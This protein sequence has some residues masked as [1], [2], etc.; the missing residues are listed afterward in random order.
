LVQILREELRGIREACLT[1]SQEYRPKVTFV[2]VQ[3]RHHT[4][5]FPANAKD[6]V[7]KS[8]NVP[9]GAV[10]DQT[11]T[12]AGAFDFYLC[13]H[14]G[15]QVPRCALSD[16]AVFIQTPLQGTSRPTRYTVVF[17]ENNF[18]AD[19]VQMLTYYL[20]HM[21]ARCPRAV[22]IPAPV[23]YADLACARARS[24]LLSMM[25]VVVRFSMTLFG[26]GCVFSG[27]GSSDVASTVS[28]GDSKSNVAEDD[29]I[30]G[31]TVAEALRNRMYFM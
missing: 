21:Y 27:E 19:E 22:S 9:P 8:R 20:C 31:A 12:S 16:D 2:V 18:S 6:A 10:V 4:R 24:H 14:F 25:C 5:L 29:L 1:L 28:G 13:S 17:D 23:Y 3:K 15:I 26:H 30:K 7:G 11:V